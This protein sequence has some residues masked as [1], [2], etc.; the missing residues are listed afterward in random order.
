MATWL[1][2]IMP[3]YNGE[4]YLAEALESVEKQGTHDLEL[5]V[6]DDGSTDDTLDILRSFQSRLPL[7]L[8]EGPRVGNWVAATNVAIRAATGRYACF[9]HQDDVWLPNRVEVVRRALEEVPAALAVHSA[10]FIDN[11][12]RPIGRWT[13][14]LGGSEPLIPSSAVV[15]RLLVQ[16]SIAILA[17]VF[18]RLAALQTGLL[19]ET[20]WYTADWDFWLRLARLGPV[21]HVPADPV[22]YRVHGHSQT[23]SRSRSRAEFQEQ[24]AVVL[25]RHLG[26]WSEAAPPGLARQV[27]RAAEFSIHVNATLASAHRGERAGWPGLLWAFAALGPSGWRRYFRDS[28]LVERT[29]ARLRAG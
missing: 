22:A 24:L 25:R 26:P 21:L 14:P 19:D 5:V 17:P 18:D 4:A 8:I 29:A 6:A 2:V 16:N 12:G 7:R 27:R 11:A 3:T 20:L 23:M 9:L 28:C 1:S 10:R 15:E 13:C